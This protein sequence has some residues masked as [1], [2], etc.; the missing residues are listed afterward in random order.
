MKNR[1]LGIIAFLIIFTLIAGCS[2]PS[3]TPPKTLITPTTTSGTGY[4]KIQPAKGMTA[5][6]TVRPTTAPQNRLVCFVDTTKFHWVEY[7]LPMGAFTAKTKIEY[8]T[9]IYN[10]QQANLERRTVTITA[11]GGSSLPQMIYERYTD[12]SGK[13]L[14]GLRKQIASDGSVSVDNG[15]SVSNFYDTYCYPREYLRKSEGTETVTVKAGT[16]VCDKYQT[17]EG[18]ISNTIYVSSGVPVPIKV[19]TMELCGWG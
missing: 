8:T 7:S 12:S 2:V 18:S 11:E 13:N 19:D 6:M 1:Y 3:S 10:G 5:S 15:G 14:G 16:F 4:V 17:I 9:G